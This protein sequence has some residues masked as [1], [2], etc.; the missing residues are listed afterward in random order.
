MILA[1]LTP[2]FTFIAFILLLLVSLSAPIIKSIYLFKLSAIVSAGSSV[3][4]AKANG[5]VDFGVWGYCVSAI[6]VAVAGINRNTAAQCS[7]KH[8]GYT[9]DSTVAH[10]LNA[11][12]IEHVISKTSTAAL[13]L[14]PIAAA[15]AFLTLLSSLFILRRGSNGTSR[16]P[17]FCTLGVGLVATILTTII[18]LID[19]ILV[20][21]VRKRVKNVS[22]GAL[23]LN[24]GN[25]VWLT[26]GA[27]VALWL[28]MLGS[29]CGIFSRG[30]R[31]KPETY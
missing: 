22:D 12:E 24:W 11:D 8:L 14:H 13:V 10:A 23:S 31:S 30:R 27:T 9:F 4:S 21:V 1:R 6:T 26:L 17:S 2:V 25:A 7:P 3:F 16:L 5:Q 28:A 19:V 20:A 18:F 15:L 29:C